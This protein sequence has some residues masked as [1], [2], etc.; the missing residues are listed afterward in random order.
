MNKKKVGIGT[1]IAAI[2][3]LGIGIGLKLSHSETN[4]LPFTIIGLVLN[5]IGLLTLLLAKRETTE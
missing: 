5:A 4:H 3:V 2:F 1:M